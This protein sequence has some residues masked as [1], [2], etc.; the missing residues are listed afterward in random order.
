MRNL[1]GRTAVA[2]S[3]CALAVGFFATSSAAAGAS[4]HARPLAKPRASSSLCHYTSSQP[5]LS[6]GSSGTA[7]KQAQCELNWAYAY[8]HSTNYGNGPY[9]GLTVDGIFGAN[10][11]AATRAFQSCVHIG[12]DGI[13][14]PDTWSEL[15]YWV[16]QSGYA[17]G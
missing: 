14:G 17:C 11:N 6:E 13:I 8:G 12:V 16:N 9:G 15:N 4:T 2:V 7:V 1:W 3:A 5:Q 10:T